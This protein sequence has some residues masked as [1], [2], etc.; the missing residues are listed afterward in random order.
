[1]PKG[2]PNAAPPNPPNVVGGVIPPEEGRK[3]AK[4]VFPEGDSDGEWLPGGMT[5]PIPTITLPRWCVLG[6]AAPDCC[7]LNGIVFLPTTFLPTVGSGN[8]NVVIFFGGGGVVG[9]RLTTS[10]SGMSQYIAAASCA[11]LS[12]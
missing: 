2:V 9:L 7:R 3:A 4:L 8:G 10:D 11:S 6:P 5:P 1:M 12:T